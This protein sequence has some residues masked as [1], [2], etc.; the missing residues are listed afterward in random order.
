[1]KP[2]KYKGFPRF[3]KIAMRPR[4]RK[5][6]QRRISRGRCQL[7]ADGLKIERCVYSGFP[8]Q[9]EWSEAKCLLWEKEQLQS[10]S[11]DAGFAGIWRIAKQTVTP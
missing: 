3:G 9:T 1:V 6:T 2:F 4:V 8:Q 5:F 11:E 7:I 10:S